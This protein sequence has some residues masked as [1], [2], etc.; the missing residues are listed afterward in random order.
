MKSTERAIRAWTAL[1]PSRFF[2]HLSEDPMPAEQLI[3]ELQVWPRDFD[4]DVS[5]VLDG[6]QK[7]SAV[8]V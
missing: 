2:P 5:T 8:A 3:S 7:P 4:D 1:S 6:S